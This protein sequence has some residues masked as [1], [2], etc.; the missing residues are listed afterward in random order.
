MAVDPAV[1]QESEVKAHCLH[2]LCS[3]SKLL[4]GQVHTA[5]DSACGWLSICFCLVQICPTWVLSGST[6]A[7]DVL[8]RWMSLQE[9][10]EE[11]EDLQEL[12]GHFR[13]MQVYMKVL[14]AA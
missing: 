12:M 6:R 8:T 14:L 2:A 13:G 3:I 1:H 7:P 11:E 5:C 9:E 10:E 4:Q